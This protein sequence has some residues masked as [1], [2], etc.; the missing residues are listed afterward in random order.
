MLTKATPGCGP[1]R[2][3]WVLWLYPNLLAAFEHFKRS[4]VKF[5]AKLL[6]ELALT[7]LLRQDSIFTE[8]SQD[9]KDNKLL[10]DKTYYSWIQQFMDV[11]NIVLLSQRG[12]LT[13]SIEK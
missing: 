12:R 7:V 3:K 2:S 5:S 1:K 8:Q 4:I 10:I 13:C 11:H 6:Y 9:L